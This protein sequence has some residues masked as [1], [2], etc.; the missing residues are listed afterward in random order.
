MNS[1]DVTSIP[2]QFV[3]RL[4][5]QPRKSIRRPPLWVSVLKESTENPLHNYHQ[6]TKLLYRPSYLMVLSVGIFFYFIPNIWP[7]ILTELTH[8]PK[9]ICSLLLQSL[10]QRVGIFNDEIIH[11][12][13]QNHPPH[14]TKSST[15]PNEIIHP[16]QQNH[17]PHPTKSSTPSNGVIHPTQRNHPPNPTKLSTPPNEI[18]HNNKTRIFSFNI[19]QVGCAF[20]SHAGDKSLSPYRDRPNNT[21]VIKIG[22]ENSPANGQLIGSL[23]ETIK[24][25]VLPQWA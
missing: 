15:Q 10:G 7:D 14:P 12:T 19:R 23:D 20:T 2:S 5:R 6:N 1:S 8:P 11:H 16:T 9:I 22:T 17:P 25:E 13:Q 3:H 21:Q 4:I 18:I 24:L